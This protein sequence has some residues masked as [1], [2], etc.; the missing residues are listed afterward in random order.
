MGPCLGFLGPHSNRE[1]VMARMGIEAQ[2]K[3]RG[4]KFIT[5]VELERRQSKAKQQAKEKKV[6]KQASQKK[7]KAEQMANAEMQMFDH[8][9]RSSKGCCGDSGCQNDEVHAARHVLQAAWELGGSCKGAAGA[10]GWF[11]RGGED[12]AVRT[13]QAGEQG[14]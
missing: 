1:I 5:I 13:S 9:C 6:A 11:A 7:A 12:A 3:Q 2:G 4:T 10:S 14:E 8:Q